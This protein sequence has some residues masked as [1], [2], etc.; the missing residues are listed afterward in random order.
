[1]AYSNSV[2]ANNTLITLSSP[3][4]RTI[5]WAVIAAVVL[6]LTTIFDYQWLRSFA[7]PLYFVNLG[8]LV[9]TLRLEPAPVRPVPP[10]GG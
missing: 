1:M 4:V 5:M 2:G 6:G 7:W 9:M 3:F 10:R 8:L